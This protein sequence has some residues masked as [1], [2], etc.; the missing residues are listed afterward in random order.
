MPAPL[1]DFVVYV[2]DV[3]REHY[4]VSKVL[5]HNAPKNVET[6]VGPVA[7]EIGRGVE[8][9]CAIKSPQV[10]STV[11]NGKDVNPY[12]RCGELDGERASEP[13]LAWPI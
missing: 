7:V 1:N 5:A 12:C 8:K 13:H 2:C 6:N 11:S 4:V 3:H 10:F 9:S